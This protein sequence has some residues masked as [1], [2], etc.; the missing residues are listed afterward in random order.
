MQT[1][2]ERYTN[3]GLRKVSQRANPRSATSRGPTRSAAQT[4]QGAT[5]CLVRGGSGRESRVRRRRA[6]RPWR[7]LAH[8]AGSERSPTSSAT[9]IAE[10]TE[11]EYGRKS[12]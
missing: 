4:E 3:K 12:R 7:S 10:A 11:C 1:Y 2:L 6:P 5:Q 9:A 8:L